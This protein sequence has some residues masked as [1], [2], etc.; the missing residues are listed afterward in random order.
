MDV[1]N[2]V[3]DVEGVGQRPRR[4]SGGGVGVDRGVRSIRCRWVSGGGGVRSGRR[5]WQIPRRRRGVVGGVGVVDV[6]GV[7]VAGVVGGRKRW[8]ACLHGN[9]EIGRVAWRRMQGPPCREIDAGR[10]GDVRRGRQ[11]WRL[12]V[13]G[14]CRRPLEGRWIRHLDH[15]KCYVVGR[16]GGQGWRMDLEIDGRQ[17]LAP[18]S[19]WKIE[20]YLFIIRYW[21]RRYFESVVFVLFVFRSDFTLG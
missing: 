16:E 15:R 21:G 5:G 7:G 13:R 12:D 8:I 20:G 10:G 11:P 6:G 1:R 17:T 9:W 18:Y 19:Y 2:G 14:G 4:R 3:N